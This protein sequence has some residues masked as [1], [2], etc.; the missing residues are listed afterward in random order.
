MVAKKQVSLSRSLDPHPDTSLLLPMCEQEGLITADQKT[1][2]IS[3]LTTGVTTKL[4]A[5]TRLLENLRNTGTRGYEIFK[6]IL[7]E[8][9]KESITN[10]NLYKEIIAKEAEV[11]NAR[12]AR[13]SRE[14]AT[15]VWLV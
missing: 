12:K 8:L 11:R 3:S 2:I 9:A 14:T 7:K 15:Q 10:E 1:A 4:A 5:N 13:S 6:D